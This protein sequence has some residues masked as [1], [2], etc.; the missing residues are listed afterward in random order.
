MCRLAAYIGAKISLERFLLAPSHSLFRQSWA[1]EEMQEA[2]INADGFGFCWSSDEDRML[3]YKSILPVWSDHNLPAL[4]QCL[5]SG[6]WM[7]NVRSATLGQGL[8]T[9]NT[10]PFVADGLVYL[11]NG[12][13]KPFSTGVKGALLESL[14]SG[15]RAEINGNTDSEYVFALI[16]QGF[17]R[18]GKA[19]GAIREAMRLLESVC[20]G[21]EAMLNVALYA[22]GRLYV[23][24]HAV[25]ADCP[26][27]Y[28]TVGNERYPGGALAASERLDGSDGWRQVAEHS[29]M[30]LSP[31][32]GQVVFTL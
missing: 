27:L 11:H 2:T 30:E 14:S 5:K 7:A 24:R 32:G 21:V 6:V 10:Q 16:R 25:N 15:L 18:E 26:S 8:S 3:S 19:A 1:A 17:A 28:Y 12:Y 20:Q 9:A 13:I 23:C 22:G 29:V 31:E 4:G